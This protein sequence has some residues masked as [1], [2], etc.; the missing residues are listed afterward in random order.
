MVDLIKIVIMPFSD[1]II[2]WR[3]PKIATELALIFQEAM[4]CSF[5]C[6]IGCLW[7]LVILVAFYSHDKY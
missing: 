3:D 2:A 1:T 4:G 7:V 5:I 6:E